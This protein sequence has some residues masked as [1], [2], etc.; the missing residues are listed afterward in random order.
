M[1]DVDTH[2]KAGSLGLMLKGAEH[3]RLA[4]ESFEGAFDQENSADWPVRLHA[5]ARVVLAHLHIISDTQLHNLYGSGGEATMA[6]IIVEAKS[7][8]EHQSGMKLDSLD[9]SPRKPLKI[10]GR[11][12]PIADISA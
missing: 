1:L 3:L 12:E 8:V 9:F 5:H 2:Q 7:L 11:P 10:A 6:E 4:I